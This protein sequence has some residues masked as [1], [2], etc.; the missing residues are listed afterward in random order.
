[1]D[2][3]FD[4]KHKILTLSLND[5]NIFVLKSYND[6]YLFESIPLK[7]LE[8]KEKINKTILET[9]ELFKKLAAKPYKH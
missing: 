2:V 6:N 7:S 3:V 1:M 9:E 8:L 5:V 4:S